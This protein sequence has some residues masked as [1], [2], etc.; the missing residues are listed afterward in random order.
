MRI[1]TASQG[2]NVLAC[3]CD[4]GRDQR[5]V[6]VNRAANKAGGIGRMRTEGLVRLPRMSHASNVH[7]PMQRLA[8]ELHYLPSGGF[9]GPCGYLHE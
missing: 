4:E 7:E 6:C 1:G 8:S 2:R 5:Q 9:A 3:G